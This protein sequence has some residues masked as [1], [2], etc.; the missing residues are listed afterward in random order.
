MDSGQ[1]QF[2]NIGNLL[3]T[4]LDAP[5]EGLLRICLTDLRHS[6]SYIQCSWRRNFGG[7]FF[8]SFSGEEDFHFHACLSDESGKETAM[9]CP[10]AQCSQG[11]GTDGDPLRPFGQRCG[12]E[13]E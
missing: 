9:K 7:L 6:Q 10:A 5:L 11:I 8:F 4:V 12:K 3:A 13:E 2:L 1:T